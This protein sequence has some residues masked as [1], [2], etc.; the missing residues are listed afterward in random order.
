M[1]YREDFLFIF[2]FSYVI[3]KT[4]GLEK[5]VK[6]V[7]EEN[8]TKRLQVRFVECRNAMKGID[9][10]QKIVFPFPKLMEGEEVDP[11]N[12][13]SLKKFA[14]PLCVVQQVVDP[15][16]HRDADNHLFARLEGC[17]QILQDWIVIHA[18][19]FIMFL[20]VVMLAVK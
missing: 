2:N 8:R 19:R 1:P 6:A 10:V 7:F 18:G 9:P 12:A 20:P 5:A 16:D 3:R 17:L 13:K 15:R 11:L 14:E 4:S